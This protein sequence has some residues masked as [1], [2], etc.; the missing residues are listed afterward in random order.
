MTKAVSWQVYSTQYD[1]MAIHNPAYHE[2]KDRLRAF[3]RKEAIPDGATI[4]DIGAGTGNYSAMIAAA[5]PRSSILHIEPNEGMNQVARAKRQ[6]EG[7]INLDIRQHVA[8]E[9]LFPA[10]SLNGVVLVHSLYAIPRPLDLVARIHEWVCDGGFVF[11]CDIG[12]IMNVNDWFWYIGRHLLS[13]YGVRRT[14]QLLYGNREVARQNRHVARSQRRG[15]FWLHSP[16]E[17]RNAWEERG[18]VIEHEEVMYRGYSDLIIAR[19]PLSS[20]LAG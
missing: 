8:G 10:G 3:I 2:I 5:L 15:E 9:L 12:R 13:R 17:Y 20:A 7:L 6:R 18:F 11:A 14:I 4:A 19:K 16:A 1:V